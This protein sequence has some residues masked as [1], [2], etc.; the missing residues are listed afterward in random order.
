VR[1][2]QANARPYFNADPA[3]QRDCRRQAGF[4]CPVEKP[5]AGVL[6]AS[7]SPV[8]AG[9]QVPVR[10]SRHIGAIGRPPAGWCCNALKANKPPVGYAPAHALRTVMVDGTAL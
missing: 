9:N 7:L 1:L 5:G 2:L 8:A 10:R 3:Q 6:A 4:S